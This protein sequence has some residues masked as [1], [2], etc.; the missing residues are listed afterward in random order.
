MIVSFA[1]KETESFAQGQRVKRF[2][3]FE[4]VAQRKIRQLQIAGALQ[5]LRIPPGNHLEKLSGDREGS[6]SIR[7]NE[8]F[9]IC[10]RWTQAGP[11]DVEI[12]DY[13]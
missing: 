8:Q 5:D 6:W 3:P 12:V 1:N 10:F 11:A 4:R 2:V 13:H 9:R 7:I